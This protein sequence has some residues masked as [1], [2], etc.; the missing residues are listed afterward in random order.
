MSQ[1]TN[2]AETPTRTK[3]KDLTL[4]LTPDGV[5][6]LEAKAKTLGISKSELIER[7]ARNQASSAPERQMMGEWSAN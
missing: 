7:I 6:M 3:E 4:T 1:A 5:E 2:N